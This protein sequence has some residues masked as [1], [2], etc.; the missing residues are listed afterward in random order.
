MP[1]RK[2]RFWKRRL[3]VR[4]GRQLCESVKPSGTVT[5]SKAC[6]PETNS[7]RICFALLPA[8]IRY[9]PAFREVP[10]SSALAKNRKAR[11]IVCILFDPGQPYRLS[12]ISFLDG[13]QGARTDAFGG[14]IC[15]CE[16]KRDQPSGER[17][18]AEAAPIDC[19]SIRRAS[20]SWS[21]CLRVAL[22]QL[23]SAL[24]E[25]GE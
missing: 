13:E 24:I 4:G 18:K 10:W 19:A 17:K 9:V 1:P 21:S 2:N 23:R 14:A 16:G 8:R 11:R 12:A 7:S 22:R 6:S 15:K 3:G 20:R 25:F 5:R